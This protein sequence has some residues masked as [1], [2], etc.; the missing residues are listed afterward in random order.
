MMKAIATKMRIELTCLFVG[1]IHY[2]VSLQVESVSSEKP[3]PC[4]KD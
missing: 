3:I 1:G 2:P 4:Q